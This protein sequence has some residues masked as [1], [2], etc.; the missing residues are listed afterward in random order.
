M[1]FSGLP[2]SELVVPSL[3]GPKLRLWKLWVLFNQILLSRILL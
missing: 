1:E 3:E 2:G